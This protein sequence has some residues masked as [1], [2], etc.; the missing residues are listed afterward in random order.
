MQCALISFSQA[1]A[2]YFLS[3]P[4]FLPFGMLMYILCHCRLEALLCILIF[5]VII[6]RLLFVTGKNLNFEIVLRI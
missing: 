4:Q 1:S 3:E 6:E 2:Y 5:Q